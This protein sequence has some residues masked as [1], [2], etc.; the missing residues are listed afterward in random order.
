MSCSLHNIIYSDFA[1]NTCVAYNLLAIIVSYD[2]DSRPRGNVV[3]L[4]TCPSCTEHHIRYMHRVYY[5]A[6]VQS[7]RPSYGSGVCFLV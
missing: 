6:G 7:S 2:S 4:G 5:T 3:A 1:A